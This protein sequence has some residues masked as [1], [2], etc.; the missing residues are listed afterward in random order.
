MGSPGPPC[1]SSVVLCRSMSSTPIKTSTDPWYD[2]LSNLMESRCGHCFLWYRLFHLI[3]FKPGVID[4]LVHALIIWLNVP[5][6]LS[7]P[8]CT[9]CV[10]RVWLPV[11]VEIFKLVMS[12]LSPRY[13]AISSLIYVPVLPSSRKAMALILLLPFIKSTGAVLSAILWPA[14]FFT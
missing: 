7:I 14:N 11:T 2:T 13:S 4:C 8:T 12:P 9:L 10:S 6:L 1:T 3:I 5:S